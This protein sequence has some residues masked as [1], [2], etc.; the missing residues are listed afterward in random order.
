MV[1]NHS[2]RRFRGRNWQDITDSATQRPAEHFACVVGQKAGDHCPNLQ[3]DFEVWWHRTYI[4]PHVEAQGNLLQSDSST[5][6]KFCL[7]KSRGHEIIT[8]DEIDRQNSYW[9]GGAVSGVLFQQVGDLSEFL[10][11]IQKV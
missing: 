8:E 10:S 3:R 7:L 9:T 1:A 11:T 2:I 4:R 5:T 6:S